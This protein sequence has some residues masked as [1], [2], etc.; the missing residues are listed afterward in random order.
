MRIITESQLQ[1]LANVLQDCAGEPI[2]LNHLAGVLGCS[3]DAVKRRLRALKEAKKGFMKV[4][5]RP[6][7][8]GLRGPMSLGYYL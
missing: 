2:T 5:A 6:V 7:R 4:K 8:E 1:V 3:R